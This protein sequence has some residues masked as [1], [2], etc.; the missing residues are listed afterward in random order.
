MS[1]SEA[2]P[3]GLIMAGFCCRA[4]GRSGWKGLRLAIVVYFLGV[5]FMLLWG[6]V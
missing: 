5:A 1:I 6:K 2:W 4:Y 3:I